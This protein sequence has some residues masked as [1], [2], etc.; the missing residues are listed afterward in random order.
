ML[1]R[2]QIVCIHKDPRFDAFH[3]IERIG[4]RDPIAGKIV[5]IPMR[6]ACRNVM[7]GLASYYVSV[8]LL[9]VEVEAVPTTLMG[10][11]YLRTRPDHTKVDNLLSLP[12]CPCSHSNKLAELLAQA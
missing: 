2:F 12:D 8:G 5:C 3:P 4:Y 6:E 1:N 10:T 7:A 9:H 11:G